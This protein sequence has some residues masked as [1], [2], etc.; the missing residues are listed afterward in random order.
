MAARYYEL[1][2]PA[3]GK[4]LEL[5]VIIGSQGPIALDVSQLYRQQGIFTYDPGFMSTASCESSIT[6][7]DGEAGV[8]E[9]RGYPIEQLAA[10]SSFPEVAYLLLYGELPSAA[11]LAEFE[12]II[13]YHTMLNESLKNFY[14]GFHHDAHPMAIM[15]GVVGSL[16]AFYHDSLDIGDPRHREISAHR[17]FAKMPTIAA[18]CYKH[19]IGE[20]II[21]PRN[22]LTYC[23]N[24][25]NMMFSSPCE[26]YEIDPV[27]AKAV[28]LLFILHAD[29]EQN[30]S[31][32]TVRLAG[33]SHANPFACIAAGIASLWGPAHGGANEAVLNMLA[34]IGDVSQIDKYIAKAK[35]KNDPFRLMGFGHRVYKNFDPRADILRDT[36]KQV[37]EKLA[38]SNNPLFDLA[39]KLEEIALHDDYFISRKLY[40][41]VDFY[42]G[43]IYRALGIPNSMFTVMFAIGRTI[44]WVAHWM[45]MMSDPQQKIGRPRQ[46]YKGNVRRDYLPMES[47]Q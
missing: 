10:H 30:A 13:T 6:Y 14:N 28:D 22:D 29:H 1:N 9:Y 45:E 26:P 47:R 19:N 17:L 42:S 7:I 33:S 18:A 31:T 27:A 24:F 41:N 37:L 32:S 3:N 15:I 39:L 21:Y 12:H 8:L 38:D 40:P 35:D 46:I 36:A 34:E 20:P 4:A 16:S 11:Q 23:A 44:G 43:V 2:E 25:L 5:P